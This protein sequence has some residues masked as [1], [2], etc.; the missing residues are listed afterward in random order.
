MEKWL[1]NYNSPNGIGNIE[2]IC[3][4][5]EIKE[6][7]Q[8]MLDYSINEIAL[9]EVI[10]LF[11]SHEDVDTKKT[12]ITDNISQHMLNNLIDSWKKRRY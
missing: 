2:L 3:K 1:V 9:L 11:D 4:K 7:I 10:K 8:R 5:N 6:K 12:I